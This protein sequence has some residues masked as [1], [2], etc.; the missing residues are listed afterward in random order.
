MRTRGTPINRNTMNPI[1]TMNGVS[2]PKGFLGGI[3][4]SVTQDINISFR[5]FTFTVLTLKFLKTHKAPCYCLHLDLSWML[6]LP[7][8]ALHL[9]RLFCI[10][11]LRCDLDLVFSAS[12]TYILGRPCDLKE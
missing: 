12:C 5:L 4:R 7:F 2:I 9:L 3:L 8:L 6:T 1:K 10:S 11:V